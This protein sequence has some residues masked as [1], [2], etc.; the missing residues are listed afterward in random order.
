MLSKL[1]IDTA[2]ATLLVQE[3][4]LKIVEWP[5]GEIEIGNKVVLSLGMYI[6]YRPLSYPF[7]SMYKNRQTDPSK[8]FATIS[9]RMTTSIRS[10]AQKL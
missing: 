10:E 2:L 3:S 1:K 7:R 4:N 6:I 8:L 5:C 9:T